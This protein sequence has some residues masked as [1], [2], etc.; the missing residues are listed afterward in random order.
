MTDFCI[1]WTMIDALE[2]ASRNLSNNDICYYYLTRTTGGYSKSSANGRIDNFKKDPE[3]YRHRQDVWQYKTI[4]V[5]DFAGD[6]IEFLL[7]DSFQLLLRS[8]PNAILTPIP[9]SRPKNHKYYDSRLEDLCTLVAE[10][11]SQIV[12]ENPFDVTEV[13]LPAHLGG[14][15]DIQYLNSKIR[16]SGFSS[17]SPNLVIL[18]DDVLTTGNHYIVCRDK[19]RSVYPGTQV[20]GMFLSIHRDDTGKDPEIS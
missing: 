13:L 2:R 6:V 20:I 10:E 9:T 18:I 4:E 5:E 12:Y 8:F 11:V 3:E 14:R 1:N 7:R 15:R 19:I 16:F 17:P